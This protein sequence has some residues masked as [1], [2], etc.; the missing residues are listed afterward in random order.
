MHKKFKYF[1]LISYFNLLFLISFNAYSA[2]LTDEVTT[3]MQAFNK[4]DFS[5]A[6][7]VSDAILQSSPN[8]REAL[9]CKGRALGA[10]GQYNEALTVLETAAKQPQSALDQM[11]S[12]IFIGNLHK[13]N[14]K[15]EAALASYAKSLS[16]SDVEKN[17]QFKRISLN[18]M[19]EA[20]AQSNDLNAALANYLASLKLAK[21]DNER[22]DNYER[23]GATYSA[24]GQH[25]LAIEYQLKA[26]LMQQKSGTLDQYANA[27][28]ALGQVYG[29]AKDYAGAEKTYL[30]LIQFSQ[31]NGGAYYEAKA[32]YDFAQLK[33]LK[34]DA[35]GAKSM[36]V[37]ALKLAKNSGENE[38]AAQIESELKKL[39]H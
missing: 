15:N 34:G 2:T 29:K 35:D 24:L 8:H 20:H 37:N 7:A 33:A 28:L 23:L 30:K 17:D 21:N 12:H 36:M 32:S 18:L 10:Q 26:M 22:A 1:T 4:R 38:L 16:I 6:I 19:G 3:C 14:N 31:E 5:K 25:D 9:L 13:E 11:I 27:S 39:N